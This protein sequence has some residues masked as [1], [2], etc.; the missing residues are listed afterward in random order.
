MKEYTYNDLKIGMKESF[1]KKITK[2]D[3]INFSNMTG[4][5]NPLHLDEEFAK[6]TSYKR[7]V[8]FG[9]LVNS[10][11]STLAGMYLPGKY[12]LILSVESKFK[13][14]CFIDDELTI[15]GE[16]ER[17]VDGLNLIFVNTKIT[18]QSNETIQ[19]GKMCIKVM[20]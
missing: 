10:Y 12:S 6:T 7:P 20:K 15:H 18:N 9:L 17:K 16:V 14:P 3:I 13:K 2:E 11:L 19:E 1:L 5:K 4:D 8:V